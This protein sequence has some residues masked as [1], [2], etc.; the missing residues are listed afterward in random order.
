MIMF[1]L[2]F[3]SI[4]DKFVNTHDRFLVTPPHENDSLSTLRGERA[5]VRGAYFHG[6]KSKRTIFRHSGLDPES[7]ILK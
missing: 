6:K 4:L 3:L 7:S 2:L 5:G 1:R